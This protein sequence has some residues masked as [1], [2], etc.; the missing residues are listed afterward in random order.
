ML[1]SSS[2][3]RGFESW[4]GQIKDFKIGICCFSAKHAALRR[5]SK[6]FFAR[7]QNNVSEWSDM[8]IPAD[9]CFSELALLISNSA[10]W[11]RTKRTSSS[12]HWKLT[13]SRYDIAKNIA[14][15]SLNN[16]HHLFINFFNI[17]ESRDISLILTSTF[18][19][20]Y[21][22]DNYKMLTCISWYVIEND[23][24]LSCC[25]GNHLYMS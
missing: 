11:S 25:Y 3:D 24:F 10:C 20:W 19:R 22:K 9:C 2:V 4:S 13:C 8:S 17:L 23:K 5:K 18:D 7:N 1:A 21:R 16:I 14:E 12:S 15:L 6:D